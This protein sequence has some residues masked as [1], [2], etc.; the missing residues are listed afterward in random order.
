M[1]RT[2]LNGS[3][4]PSPRSLGAGSGGLRLPATVGARPTP[5]PAAPE[6][7]TDRI[8]RRVREVPRG[9]VATYGDIDR[10]APRLVGLV[11]ATT[12][13]AVPWHRIVRADG[14]L[15]KG[16]HQRALLAR[17]RVPFRGDR[18]DMQA[19]RRYPG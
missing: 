2:V 15:P 17:E 8:L 3:Q 18:V 1:R 19:V 16:E 5:M 12:A 10:A 13:Q 4:T 6:S 9:W 11:L 14:S 7:R